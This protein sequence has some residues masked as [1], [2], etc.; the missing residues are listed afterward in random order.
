[1]VAKKAAFLF[2]LVAAACKGPADYKQITSRSEAVV[3]PVTDETEVAAMRQVRL[4][5]LPDS[6]TGDSSGIAGT[7]RAQGPCLYL[8]A[9][10]PTRYLIAFT[11]PGIRWD[12]VRQA[13][14]VPSVE[15]DTEPATYR[16]SERVILGGSEARSTIVSSQ[17]VEPPART[18][19]TETRRIW[20]AHSIAPAG[21]S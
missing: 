20:I 8:E 4:A 19:E 16:S 15:E 14:V 12:T 17:W 2:L 11:I 3:P 21:S 7:L 6:R 5:R 18:C 10:G 9:A 1:M 13:L